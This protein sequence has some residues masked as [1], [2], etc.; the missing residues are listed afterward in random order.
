M[1]QDYLQKNHIEVDA[2]KDEENLEK[3][4]PKIAE[5]PNLSLKDG[6]H[7]YCQEMNVSGE[8]KV[9][10]TEVGV[11]ALSQVPVVY[12]HRGACDCGREGHDDKGQMSAIVFSPEKSVATSQEHFL[13]SGVDQP[14]DLEDD[15]G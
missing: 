9:E 6:F 1:D 5:F 14:Q 7:G 4:V 3:K 2:V 15:G 11:A 13:I 12:I 10:D 8:Y